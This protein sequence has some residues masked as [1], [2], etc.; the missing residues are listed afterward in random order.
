MPE[1]NLKEN[2][3]L[4]TGSAHPKLAQD[5]RE[6]LNTDVYNCASKFPDGETFIEL[7]LSVRD[8]HVFII[9]PTPP[10][11]Q[12]NY[13]M[14]I[15]M[16]AWAAKTCSADRVTAIIPYIAYARADRMNKGRVCKT[17]ELVAN[18]L[19]KS[20]IDK[21]V[22]VDLHAEQSASGDGQPRKWDN[23]YGSYVLI[24]AIRQ[25]GFDQTKVRVIAPDPNASGRADFFNNQLG[26]TESI[27][28]AD[29]SRSKDPSK[30]R[31][32]VLYGDFQ[33]HTCI[34]VDDMVS[35]GGTFDEL[36]N[37]LKR[38]GATNLYIA[39][40]HGIFAPPALDRIT[41]N[42][43]IPDGGVM[44]TDTIP[45]RP[46]VLG[47]DKINVYKIAPLIAEYIQRSVAKESGISTLFSAIADKVSLY[48]P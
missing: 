29:K 17:I 43:L 28:T 32:M 3:I 8:K 35:T 45:P 16:M 13:L 9:Q 40:T 30:L 18:E 12:N 7:P 4:L 26:F 1:R 22:T 6:L 2:N 37:I 46:E 48:T 19:W 47:N 42:E 44:V 24:P 10:P 5:L 41:N 11:F 20:G 38:R 36:T 21:I 39:A 34:M 23:F 27:A 15:K 25:L 33:N 14:E 31:K